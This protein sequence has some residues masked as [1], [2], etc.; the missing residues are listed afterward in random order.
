MSHQ[1]IDEI[2]Q[3]A[4]ESRFQGH[5]FY[6]SSSAASPTQVGIVCTHLYVHNACTTVVWIRGWTLEIP[7]LAYT[8][9]LCVCPALQLML[10]S[11]HSLAMLG[12]WM[13][14]MMGWNLTSN[15]VML[16]V[17]SHMVRFWCIF[18]PRMSDDGTIKPATFV[19][20]GAGIF[21]GYLILSE[22][23]M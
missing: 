13:N 16:S 14:D 5:L 6:V 10:I 3:V 1:R 12:T 21:C 20:T 9:H 7:S 15:L 2:R 19:Y 23:D 11:Q 17:L 8:C 4:L 22:I 18:T